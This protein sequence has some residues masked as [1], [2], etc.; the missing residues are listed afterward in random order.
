MGGP[1]KNEQNNP[2]PESKCRKCGSCMAPRELREGWMDAGSPLCRR[3]PVPLC[4]LALGNLLGVPSCHTTSAPCLFVYF[5]L[6]TD[7]SVP[8]AKL[9]DKMRVVLGKWGQEQGRGDKNKHLPKMSRE[10]LTLGV[11]VTQGGQGHGLLCFCAVGHGW[12][13]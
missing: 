3:Y 13:V 10:N 1:E 12:M 8:F 5:R 2:A 11:N 7:K 6:R 9:M 4:I